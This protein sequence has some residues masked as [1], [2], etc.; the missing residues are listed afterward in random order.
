MTTYTVGYFV[1]S[2]ATASINRLLSKALVRLA[3]PELQMTE[4]PFKDLPFYSYDYDKAF[5][6]VATQ[7]KNAIAAVD[8]VLFVTPG[9]Q[10]ID[11][12]RAEERHRLGE[13]ARTAECVHPEALRRDRHLAGKDRHRD[14]AA[15]PAQH[16]RLLRLAADGR[17]GLHP[18]REGADHATTAGHGRKDDRSS[19]AN[20]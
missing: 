8:A 16:P 10:P 7:F 18:V 1:G 5:P 14:R 20:T 11:S 12:R 19:F 4:I 6:P 3:P 17:R 9:V 13:P 2:L 15:A